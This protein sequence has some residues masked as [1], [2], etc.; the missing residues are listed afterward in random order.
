MTPEIRTALVM[1]EAAVTNAHGGNARKTPLLTA[2]QL[3]E[4]GDHLARIVRAAEDT[5][6]HSGRP[7]DQETIMNGN[8]ERDT[9]RLDALLSSE[10]PEDEEYDTGSLAREDA[11]NAWHPGPERDRWHPQLSPDDPENDMF[12]RYAGGSKP[13]SRSGHR[14]QAMHFAGMAERSDPAFVPGLGFAGLIHAVLALSAPAGPEE[15]TWRQR[16]TEAEAALT[17]I[18]G[19]LA[20]RNYGR[21]TSRDIEIERILRVSGQQADQLQREVLDKAA[22]YFRGRGADPEA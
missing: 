2:A 19:V 13:A 21:K 4:A 10:D 22:R 6:E 12:H 8:D 18:G 3:I 17:T 20:D 1:W 15:G 9:P 16:A 7:E 11:R 14:T 5:R